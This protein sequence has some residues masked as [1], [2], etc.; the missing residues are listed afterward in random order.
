[1]PLCSWCIS[2]KA[3]RSD[4]R[5]DDGDSTT[6]HSKSKVGGQVAAS[7]SIAAGGG[8]LF[9][10]YADPEEPDIMNAEGLERLYSAADVPMDGAR[11]LLLAWQLDAKELGSFAREDWMKG[12]EVLGVRNVQSLSAVL[13]DLEDLLILRKAPPPRPATQSISKSIKSRPSQSVIDKYKKDRY[14][15]YVANVEAAFSKFY[16]FLFTLMKKE[17]SRNIS[18]EFA[19]ALWS[20][21]LVPTYP[22]M[23]EVIEFINEKGTYKGVNKDLWTMMK[24]FCQTVEPSLDGYDSDGAWPSLLDDFVAWKKGKC[25]VEPDDAST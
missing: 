16:V 25:G 13:V 7:R 14:W 22:I 9:D 2:D 1:M 3:T 19:L 12:L 5:D 10:A 8:E 4:D 17:E 15:G 11:P 6:G 21:V 18:M 23:S 24:E 20:V